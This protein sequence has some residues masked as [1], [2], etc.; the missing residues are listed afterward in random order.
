MELWSGRIYV[1]GA[2]AAIAIAAALGSGWR[3]VGQDVTHGVFAAVARLEA[4]ASA[5]DKSVGVK[6]AP[7]ACR[8]AGAGD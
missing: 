1:A 7:G 4:Q 2:L 5:P 8:R 6:L 3:N